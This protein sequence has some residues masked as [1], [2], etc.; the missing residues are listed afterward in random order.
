MADDYTYRN[1]ELVGVLEPEYTSER[2][3][4]GSYETTE[5]PGLLRLGVLIDGVFTELLVTKA[6]VLTNSA[7]QASKQ[8]EQDRAD[9]A[10]RDEAAQADESGTASTASKPSTAKT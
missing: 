10:E 9:Q 6:G 2:R 4:D 3:G 7:A 1:L 5:L 8:R